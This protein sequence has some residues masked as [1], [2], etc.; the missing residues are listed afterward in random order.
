MPSGTPAAVTTV[1]RNA[2]RT[3]AANPEFRAKMETA[4]APVAYLD[5]PE[6]GAAFD[7][8]AQRLNAV[9]KGIGKL[10]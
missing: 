1:L 8:E 3:V 7:A 6:F 9:L 2:F 5:G 4:G 10:E